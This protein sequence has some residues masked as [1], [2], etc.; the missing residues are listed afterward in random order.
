[1]RTDVVLSPR[2][3]GELMGLV[4]DAAVL[5]HLRGAGTFLTGRRGK[6]VASRHV[7]LVDRAARGDASRCRPF[8]DE[9]VRTRTLRIVDDGVFEDVLTNRYFATHYGERPSGSLSKPFRL[10][11]VIRP[12]NLVLEPGTLERGELFRAARLVITDLMGFAFDLRS[13]RF[14]RSAS[15]FTLRKGTLHEAVSGF[16][17]VGSLRELLMGVVAVGSDATDTS[18]GVFPSILV[19]DAEIA[20]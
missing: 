8:D 2:V 18:L 10:P 7:S 6:R 9:G 12:T 4:A 11:G 17:F 20:G 1:M 19:K 16:L 13:G 15:G 14:G 3:V 5:P